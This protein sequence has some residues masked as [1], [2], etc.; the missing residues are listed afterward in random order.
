MTAPNTVSAYPGPSRLLTDLQASRMPCA[1]CQA[2][3]NR[4]GFHHLTE[5]QPGNRDAIAAYFLATCRF[6]LDRPRSLEVDRVLVVLSERRPAT[7]P[8]DGVGGI[9]GYWY[10]HWTTV[11]PIR[12]FRSE[13]FERGAFE[14]ITRM[15]DA[16]TQSFDRRQSLDLRIGIDV[17]R[18][19]TGRR[20][21]PRAVYSQRTVQPTGVWPPSGVGYSQHNGAE[22]LITPVGGAD[23]YCSW[24]F[25]RFPLPK[26]V[27]QL[28]ESSLGN[29]KG[30]RFT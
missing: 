17:S 19:T 3:P 5:Q 14:G 8:T 30:T 28:L 22:A 21:S 2:A 20:S 9:C 23:W 10:R 4:P 27:S 13:G 29:G 7:Q 18:E 24:C 15:T 6:T 11:L 12:R 25:G 26:P 16:R 1:P